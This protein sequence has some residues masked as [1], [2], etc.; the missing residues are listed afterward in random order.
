[1]RVSRSWIHALAVGG[2]VAALALPLGAQTKPKPIVPSPGNG[3]LYIGSTRSESHIPGGY[4]LAVDAQTGKVKWTLQTP[5]SK[6]FEA[7]PAGA[8]GKIYLMNFGG[9]V[10]V[11]DAA[12]GEV[13]HTAQLGDSTDNETRSSIA[14]AQGHLFVRTN[15]KLYCVGAK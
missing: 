1:M 7:S 8:D 4:V 14:I 5:G 13:L 2:A 9:D 6:K 3:T 12:K 11:V 15:S 10:V